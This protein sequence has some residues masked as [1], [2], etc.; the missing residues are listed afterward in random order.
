V[1][2]YLVSRPSTYSSITAL[3]PPSPSGDRSFLNNSDDDCSM[4]VDTHRE[5]P[6]KASGSSESECS[7]ESD[8]EDEG[9]Q[10]YWEVMKRE[11]KSTKVRRSASRHKP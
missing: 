9:D 4:N 2:N 1:P 10:K 3:V 7:D 6:E 5:E 8:D 11:R